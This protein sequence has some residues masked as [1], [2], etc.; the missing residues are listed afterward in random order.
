MQY[1]I[2]LWTT[3]A[4]ISTLFLAA[5]WAGVSALHRFGLAGPMGL[6]AFLF[7]LI[8]IWLWVKALVVS[9]FVLGQRAVVREA[10]RGEHAAGT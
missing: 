10:A 3:W 5:I 2:E 7:G 9:V 1:R 4:L 6:V 8:A